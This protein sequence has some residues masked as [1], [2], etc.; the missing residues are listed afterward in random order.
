[1]ADMLIRLHGF[2]PGEEIKIEYT[3][4]R[5]GEKLFEELFYDISHVDATSHPK[6][7]SSRLNISSGVS[8]QVKST[9]LQGTDEVV[10]LII[11]MIPEF[12]GDSE[13]NR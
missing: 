2:I 4:I 8:E 1:M 10:S 7:F 13:L 5:D 3:G 11:K 9:M 12:T 6:I